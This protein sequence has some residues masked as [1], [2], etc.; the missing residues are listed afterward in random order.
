VIV[1]KTL[2]IITPMG[3]P[4]IMN[5]AK[6]GDKTLRAIEVSPRHAS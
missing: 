1:L 2:K 3:F 6:K 5:P 4:G